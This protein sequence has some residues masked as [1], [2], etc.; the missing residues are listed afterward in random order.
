[1]ADTTPQKRVLPA[2]ERRESAAKRRA[3]SP[4]SQQSTAVTRSVTAKVNEER[5]K[6]VNKRKSGI[7]PVAT[8][9]R[10]SSTPVSTTDESLP[11]RITNT[12]PLP[13]SHDRQSERLTDREYQSI[14]DSAILSAS[15]FRSRVQWLCDGVFQ[16]YW[17]KPV[18]RKGGSDVPPNN[19]D[20]KSMQK[21]GHATIVVEPHTFDAVFY[22]VRDVPTP[23]PAS[24][25]FVPQPVRPVSSLPVHPGNSLPVTAPSAP[26][27]PARVPTPNPPTKTTD[28]VIQMLA[29]R[30]ATDNKLKEL[31]K[32]VATSRAST[33][34]LKEFQA[35]IDEFNNIV[36]Q[37]QVEENRNKVSA[38]S[39]P[40]LIPQA[41][42]PVPAATTLP[43]PRPT[44]GSVYHASPLAGRP[45]PMPRQICFEFTSL[46]HSGAPASADRWLFPEHAVV[47]R[48]YNG[49][50]LVCSFFV[51][52]RGDELLAAQP[53][54]NS[55][56]P[57]PYSHQWD[58]STEYYD[59]VTI[60]IRSSS[61]RLIDT[62][63]KAAKPLPDV[64]Q[65]MRQVMH[66]KTRAPP[67]YLV[68]RLPRDKPD[69]SVPDFVDSAVELSPGEDD[70]LQ[71]HYPL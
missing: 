63:C 52:R 15:L 3:I 30:A 20:I 22:V 40:R 31:M 28:P 34:Q 11:T 64:Q 46:A 26:S 1:M 59:P 27:Q 35:H 36:K 58:A 29:A 48:G 71:D 60:V 66:S 37:R 17:T 51:E 6:R 23:I 10:N 14:A 65:H 19:P 62:I 53:A 38:P 12:R 43:A 54:T 7:T 45:D 33:D 25:Q 16:K 5:P 70:T 18:K 55:D 39:S 24:H 50:D 4:A 42:H 8:P 9:L 21:L 13:T 2:R 41:P 56:D 44:P 67:E 49:M 47:D 61:R 32:I 57:T 69:L 68:H